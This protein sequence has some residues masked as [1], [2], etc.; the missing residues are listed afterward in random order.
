M[1]YD[2]PS[3]GP[4]NEAP[5]ARDEHG[6]L[7]PGGP[8]W[9]V[10]NVADAVWREDD[11]SVSTRFQGEDT[12]FGQYGF[13]IDVL[14]PG[15]PS[16]S[17]HREYWEDESFFVLK[18]T[19]ILLVEGEERTM[20]AGDLFHSPAGTAHAFVGGPAGCT[21]ITV[22]AR[23][24][25]PDGLDGTEQWGIYEADPVAATYGACVA[26][27]TPDPEVAYATNPPSVQVDAAWVPAE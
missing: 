11:H 10:L 1:K 8:G 6:A 25:G 24:V 26:E 23:N 21:M 14:K 16:T 17:Y 5:L 13:N 2:A 18:G 22:G 3:T 12:P 7:S 15:K 9:F 4:I 19:C 20:Q 27:D